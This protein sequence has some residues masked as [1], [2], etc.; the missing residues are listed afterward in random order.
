M[1]MFYEQTSYMRILSHN[2]RNVPN[3]VTIPE[4]IKADTAVWY[5]TFFS[6]I[7]REMNISIAS[8]MNN[9]IDFKVYIALLWVTYVN[10]NMGQD[11]YGRLTPRSFMP[12]F[13]IFPAD[14]RT[15]ILTED[16]VHSNTV[17]SKDFHGTPLYWFKVFNVTIKESLGQDTV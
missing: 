5:E 15:C 10:N 12:Y 9:L 7:R 11:A 6:Q 1:A 8:I 3:N 14:S 17:C 16:I 13:K 4:G 2:L